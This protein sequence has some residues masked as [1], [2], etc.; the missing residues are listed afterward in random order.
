MAQRNPVVEAESL[1]STGRGNEPIGTGGVYDTA[2][3]TTGTHTTSTTTA[4][5]SGTGGGVK[6]VLAGIHGVG[7]KIRGEFNKGVDGAMGDKEGVV[8]NEAVANAGDRERLT[9]T[10]AGETKNREGAMP[11]ADGERRY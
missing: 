7:E 9:G 4:G 2:G 8:K 10:F 6:G 5:H 11:E 1:S 3:S